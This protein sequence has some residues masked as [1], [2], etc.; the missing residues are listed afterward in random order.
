MPIKRSFLSMYIYGNEKYLL[1]ISLKTES[2]MFL[3]F[4]CMNE[5]ILTIHLSV[6]SKNNGTSKYTDNF[7][8]CF[9]L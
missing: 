4:R 2:Y 9:I 6:N 7:F 3:T 1:F 8:G 5:I